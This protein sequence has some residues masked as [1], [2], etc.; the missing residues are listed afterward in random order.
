M[1]AVNRNREIEPDE[2]I[3]FD[4][5]GYNHD[6]KYVSGKDVN[7]CPEYDVDFDDVEEEDDDRYKMYDVSVVISETVNL[8]IWAK[9]KE[10]AISY[11]MEEFDSWSSKHSDRVDEYKRTFTCVGESDRTT[12]DMS[13]P[14]WWYDYCYCDQ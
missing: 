4:Y 14:E 8:S 10:S 12:A 6:L 3:G 11:A 9:S 7:G 1:R 2:N 5:D 13:M